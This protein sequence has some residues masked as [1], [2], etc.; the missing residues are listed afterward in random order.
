MLGP[1]QRDGQ[2]EGP[3]PNKEE[4]TGRR[5]HSQYT[6]KRNY[7]LNDTEMQKTDLLKSGNKP[8]LHI[9]INYKTQ[10]RKTHRRYREPM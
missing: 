10:M 8:R 2:E 7:P 3:T 4:N 5:S 9:K 6:T 1:Q